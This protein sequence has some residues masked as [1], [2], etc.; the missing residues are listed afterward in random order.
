[1]DVDI[2]AGLI[3]G[4]ASAMSMNN[5]L[6]CFLGVFVGSCGDD[7]FGACDEYDKNCAE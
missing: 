7:T 1:M 4:F 6:A 2:I 5:L 3:D